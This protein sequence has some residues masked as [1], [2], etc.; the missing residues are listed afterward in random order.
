MQ[1]ILIVFL[2]LGLAACGSDDGPNTVSSDMGDVGANDLGVSTDTGGTDTGSG[3]MGTEDTSDMSDAGIE[4]VGDADTAEDFGA[5]MPVEPTCP[6]PDCDCTIIPLPEGCP[7]PP[8]QIDVSKTGVVTSETPTQDSFEVFLKSAP[9]KEVIV[10]VQSSNADEAVVFPVKLVFCPPGFTELYGS[11]ETIAAAELVLGPIT[12]ISWSRHVP[13]EVNGVKDRVDDG[14]IA[15]EFTFFVVSDDPN[16]ANSPNPKVTGM[17]TDI[18]NT[19]SVSR[20]DGLQDEAL[21]QAIFAEV[22]GQRELGYSGTNSARTMMFSAVDLD[23][24]GK[25]ECIYTGITIDEPR[26]SGGAIVQGFNTEH[27]WPQSQFGQ[28][29]PIRGD[30]HH[31]FPSEVNANTARSNYDFGMVASSIPTNPLSLV[32]SN[33]AGDIV[34]Q[35]RPERRGDI[36]RAHFYLAA[37]YRYDA[38][39]VNGFD[40]DMNALNGSVNAAEE[41]ILRQWHLDDPVDDLE[42]RRNNRIEG[43]QRNRNPFVDW[44]LLVGRVAD[45]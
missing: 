38:A 39:V 18:P 2:I 9:T 34:Y 28:Q 16:F 3:D 14:D 30:L 8:S 11:C 35:V 21:L 13:I 20:F 22:S 5:D 17:N 7:L 40:D 37:R 23:D 12:E 45:F 33:A 44:P 27:S 26:E 31:L 29:E 32:G 42:R 41:N 25:V 6:G 15:Y 10:W 36:A 1:R 24:Q 19:S 4:D 43:Y